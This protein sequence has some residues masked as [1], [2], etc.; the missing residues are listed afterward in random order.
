MP[1]HTRAPF[2]NTSSL[3]MQSVVLSSLQTNP[4]SAVS[5]G[6]QWRDCATQSPP[7]ITS[8]LPSW[9]RTMLPSKQLLCPCASSPQSFAEGSG[10]GSGSGSGLGTQPSPVM[11][12]SHGLHSAVSLHE[13]MPHTTSI[14]EQNNTLLLIFMQSPFTQ[15]CVQMMLHSQ[16][17]CPPKHARYNQNSQ[18]LPAKLP[19]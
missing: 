2:A 9:Q 4:D 1:S 10:S 11:L 13:P 6:T 19:D 8:V 16:A 15:F 7:S 12:Q 17:V 18:A 14:I 5:S 3:K